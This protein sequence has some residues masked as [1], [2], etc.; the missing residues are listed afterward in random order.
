MLFQIAYG[1]PKHMKLTK[2]ASNTKDT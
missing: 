1:Q 2:Q